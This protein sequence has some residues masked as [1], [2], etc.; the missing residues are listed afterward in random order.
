MLQSPLHPLAVLSVQKSFQV[1]AMK[2]EDNGCPLNDKDV[3]KACV[4]AS[5][6]RVVCRR[7]D[8]NV[9]D[10]F[11]GVEVNVSAG[12]LGIVIRRS[13]LEVW[14]WRAANEVRGGER[15]ASSA[16]AVSGG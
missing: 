4:L 5:W 8:L 1:S 7:R 13:E 14:P 12:G 3:K 2:I 10:H 16:S 15:V 9:R 11:E 6:R